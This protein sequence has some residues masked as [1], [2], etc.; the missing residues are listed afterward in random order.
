MASRGPLRF[1]SVTHASNGQ[2][3]KL[4]FTVVSPP[5]DAAR[6]PLARA[7]IVLVGGLTQVMQDWRG[8]DVALATKCGVPVAALDNAGMGSSA[9]P[10]GTPLEMTMGDMADDV[11]KL[12]AHLEWPRVNVA[13]LSMGGMISQT[14]ALSYPKLVHRVVL[15]ATHPGGEDASPPSEA[16]QASM[17]PA[18]AASMGVRAYTARAMALNYTPEWVAAHPREFDAIVDDA[19]KVRRPAKGMF[20]QIAAIAGFSALEDLPRVRAPTL[21]IHGDADDVVAFDDG[22]KI[23]AAIP[24]ARFLPLRG[25]GHM[26]MH[27]DGGASEAAIAAFFS[28]APAARL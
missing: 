17:N 9:V 24:G 20:A 19:I 23:A 27:M 26:M 13:G 5:P 25:V 21:V 18:D 3:L 16:F 7:P 4:G 11:A 22:R 28:E 1:L 15:C 2:R 12:C 6:R 8:L 14:L 10:K